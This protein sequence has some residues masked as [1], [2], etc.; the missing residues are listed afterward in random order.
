MHPFDQ[1]GVQLRWRR[2]HRS[3]VAPRNLRLCWLANPTSG[4]QGRLH[5]AGTKCK[6]TRQ[7]LPVC[8]RP[9][10][11]QRAGQ[12]KHTRHMEIAVAL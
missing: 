11:Q 6:W 10:L 7:C 3:V 2:Q 4:L 1:R 9:T 8:C 5:K 12:A